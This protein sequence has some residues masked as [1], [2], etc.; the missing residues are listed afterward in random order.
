MTSTTPKLHADQADS[1]HVVA[2]VWPDITLDEASSLLGRYPGLAGPYAL[3]S[4]STR[5]L[6]AANT[7]GTSGGPVFV[8]RHH[9]SVR[10]GADLAREHAFIAH[11]AAGGFPTP[12]PLPDRDG[13]TAPELLWDGREWT[14]EV[15]PLAVGEDRYRG[16]NT[17]TPYASA[18]DA[19]ASGAALARLHQA[20]RGFGNPARP[21]G[22]LRSR[23]RVFGPS[24]DPIAELERLSGE[25]PG[26]GAFLAG[27]DWR[28][29]LQPHLELHQRLH[30]L[31]AQLEPLW[32]HNDWHASNQ[33]FAGDE[34]ASVIDFGLSDLTSRVYDLAIALERNT[35]QWPDLLA[36]DDTAFRLD[37]AADFLAG[38]TAVSP[39]SPPE[40]QALPALLPLTQADAALSALEYYQRI[41]A[42]PGM[43]RWGYEGFLV[44][45]TTWFLTPA[46]R[47][48]LAGIEELLT[49]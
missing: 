26:L 47:R 42:E 9:R 37:H 1:T 22:V 25:L 48:Y 17:W 49:R 24:D 16:R 43:A 44:D 33:F 10:D 29:D 18:A 8:K 20:A 21:V 12:V 32:T 11:V 2:T 5:P 41:L 38:Y 6:S 31:W 34:V 19:R 14:Y 27:R 30:P 45:H 40:R 35:L 4:P 28:S 7:I 3:G 46:G 39:L 23:P 13:S 36:G 15:F